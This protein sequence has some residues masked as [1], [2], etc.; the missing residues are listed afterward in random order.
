MEDKIER[1]FL[2]QEL[3]DYLES[4]AQQLRD[5]SFEVEGRQR[6]VPE[7]LDTKI[8]IKERKGCVN[9][10]LRFRWSVMD[11]YDEK[12]RAQM[13]RQQTEFKELKNQLAEVFSELLDLAKMWVLPP[14][15]KVMRFMELSR[16]FAGFADP[17]W[18]SEMQEY[19]D[20]LDN[21]YLALQNKQLEMFQHELRDLK[22][23]VKACHRE[24]R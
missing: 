17:D 7:H 22:I 5:G 10:K 9:A 8:E 21:L 11:E 13:T 15:S 3:A 16:E 18:E 6:G 14:E 24:N 12:T 20:H 1:G 23:L 4:L 2:R 19:L